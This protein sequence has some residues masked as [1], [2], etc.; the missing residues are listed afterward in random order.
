MSLEYK[1]L[2]STTDANLFTTAPDG[3]Y[4]RNMQNLCNGLKVAYI[5]DQ[6]DSYCLYVYGIVLKKLNHFD[7]AKDI[8]IES[9]NKEP[10]NWASWQELTPLIADKQLV[11]DTDF[12]VPMFLFVF[13]RF[14]F[15][16]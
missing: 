7:D 1:K 14:D 9:I 2:C 16:D 12:E 6:L 5:N 15:I 10:M 4:L 11:S 8:L 13:H 3:P